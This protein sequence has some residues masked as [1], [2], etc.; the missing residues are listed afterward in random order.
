M[1]LGPLSFTSETTIYQNQ[2][3][4]HVNENE[5]NMTLNPSALSGSNGVLQ[6]NVTGSDFHPYVTAVGLYSAA[7]ELLVIG[8]LAQPFPMPSNTD[9]TFVVKWDS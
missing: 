2:A 5:F 9:V 6:N 7:N 3:R 8:K 4:C 1:I